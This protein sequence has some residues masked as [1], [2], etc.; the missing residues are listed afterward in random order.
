MSRVDIADAA[1]ADRA[2]SADP[3]GAVTG[4]AAPAPAVGSALSDATGLPDDEVEMPAP[5]ASWLDALSSVEPLVALW[6]NSMSFSIVT[7]S[8]ELP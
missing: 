8:L 1:G 2:P 3:G 6:L 7:T 5:G 4:V